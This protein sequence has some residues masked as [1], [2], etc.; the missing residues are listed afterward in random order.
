VLQKGGEEIV[1]VEAVV[2]VGMTPTNDVVVEGSP[3]DVVVV[4]I[5][6]STP[7]PAV[8]PPHTPA[9]GKATESAFQALG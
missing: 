9:G 8:A 4:G 1:L 3:T 5:E 7:A 6:V 2:V